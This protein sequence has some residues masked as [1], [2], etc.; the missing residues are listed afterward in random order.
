MQKHEPEIYQKCAH[1]LLP[2][3]YIRYKLT[4]EFA[5]DV[6]DASGMQLL[7]VKNRCWSDEVLEKLGI[8]KALMARVYESPEITGEISAAAAELTGL[9]AGT[10]VVAGAGDNAAAA[11]GTGCVKDGRSF[12]TIAQVASS[13]HIRPRWRL[14]RAGGYI[15]FAVLYRA[16]G[17]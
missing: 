14:T 5:T 6:S 16:R 1:I 12:T 4:G 8:D 7:D 17:T 9:R 13:T 10:P 2:K 11:I 3:D 15:R